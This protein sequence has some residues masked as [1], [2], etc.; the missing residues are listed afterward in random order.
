MNRI[1]NTIM[2]AVYTVV[3]L[4][5]VGCSSTKG[6][7]LTPEANRKTISNMPEWMMNTPVKDGFKY[8]SATEVSQDMQLAIDKAELKAANKLAGQMDS[9]M[10]GLVERA[11]EETGLGANS[12]IIDQFKQTQEQII[13]KSLKDYRLAKKQVQEEKTDTGYIYRAY[14]LIEYDE[15]ASQKRLLAQMK[16]DEQVYNAMRATELF[17]EM[18]RKVEA[19]RNRKNK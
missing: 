3:L 5:L 2:S 12:H 11:Q 8:H 15:G 19:Y 16:A 7:D 13:S 18:E 14:V 4:S 6:P 9:E 1:K 17:D 10:N